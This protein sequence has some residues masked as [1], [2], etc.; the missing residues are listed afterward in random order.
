MAPRKISPMIL[1]CDT[2][3]VTFKKATTDTATVMYYLC[4]VKLKLWL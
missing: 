2:V 3:I 1:E 4:R